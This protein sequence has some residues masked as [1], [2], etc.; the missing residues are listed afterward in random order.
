MSLAACISRWPTTTR[1]P[2]LPCSLRRLEPLQ[3]RGLGLLR[4]Q[5]ER[6]VDVATDEQDDQQRVPTLPT[7]TTCG[8]CP[9]TGTD[10]AGP[11]D[12]AAGCARSRRRGRRCRSRADVAGPAAAGRPAARP[13][14]AAGRTPAG[15]PPAGTACWRPAGWSSSLPSRC[16]A[17]GAVPAAVHA[18]RCR[19]PQPLRSTTWTSRPARSRGGTG[20]MPARRSPRERAA[21]R[22]AA[23]GRR[24][25]AGADRI[26]H[27]QAVADGAARRVGGRPRRRRRHQSSSPARGGA[28]NPEGDR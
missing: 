12:R 24:S 9:P 4:L 8:P 3:H 6:V 17:P 28:A 1:W 21:G 13:P 7:P 16:H 15:R 5:D 23:A 20:A 22:T 2:A 11:A 27:G 18:L 14:V 10:R 19:G 26:L 25:A